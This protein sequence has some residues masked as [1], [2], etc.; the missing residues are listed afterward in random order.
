MAD[1]QRIAVLEQHVRALYEQ[2]GALR[3]QLRARGESS[4]A[5]APA[6]AAAMAAAP[7]PVSYIDHTPAPVAASEPPP[8]PPPR[9]APR[10]PNVAPQHAP[11]I[12]L[13]KLLGRYGTIAVASLA[14]LMGVGTFLSWAIEHGLLGPTVRVV[15][16]FVGA[17]IVAGVGLWV[18][19]KR[20]VRFGNVL[21]ALSLAIVHVDAWAAGPHLQVLSTLTAL[22]IAALA[23]AALA[24]LALTSE[25]RTLF[26]IGFAGALLAPFV[27]AREPGSVV[28][29]LTYGWVVIALSLFAIRERGWR[30]VL[31]LTVIGATVYV[32]AAAGGPHNLD[33][34]WLATHAPV[35]F[36]FACAA[37]GILFAR[38]TLR[39][40]LAL[41]FLLLACIATLGYSI[42]ARTLEVGVSL[43][44]IIASYLIARELETDER[45][46]VIGNVVV[47]LGFLFA[48]IVSATDR[49]IQALAAAAL[50]VVASLLAWEDE[51]ERA[52]HLFVAAI[53]SGIAIVTWLVGDDTR[54]IAALALHAALFTVLLRSTRSRLL[55]P[56]IIFSLM[57]A[58]AWTFI[59]LAA[60]S[61][62]AY[63]PF[64][65]IP[66]LC[67][68]A[69]LC[70]WAFLAYALQPTPLETSAEHKS[71]A[72]LVSAMAI[73]V[74]FVWVRQELVEAWSPDTASFALIIYYALAG[75]ALIFAGRSRHVG[76]WR[77]VGLGLAFYASYKAFVQTFTI[78]AIGLRV[79]AR[80]MVGVF[81][82]AVAYWYR[83]PSKPEGEAPAPDAAPDAPPAGAS[84]NASTL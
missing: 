26:A 23:S 39:S 41:A 12:D 42:H 70:A 6:P 84:V 1:E 62:Y 16:G 31:W 55:V 61:P 11:D 10:A 22:T 54:C 24:A 66:S 74:A 71:L 38:D 77:A 69:V 32:L 21:L 33:N 28:A 43:F 51:E 20:D 25:E 9:A 40:K 2:L 18:R 48:T 13:E 75:L 60:R 72:S 56:P 37:A 5:P 53:A 52:H 81:L 47:P 27:T 58:S 46:L 17:I 15:L 83:A 7:E 36:A 76:L 65:T 45:W 79:G 73:G 34:S 68:L 3:E 59:L 29:L 57:I 30:P 64:A 14:I 80:I 35:I 44:G 67:A 50:T 78:N 8:P 49:S 19:E 63:P 82:A 4:P